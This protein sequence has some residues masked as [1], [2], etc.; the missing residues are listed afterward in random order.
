MKRKI[1]VFDTTLRDGEQVPGAKL[2]LE[3]K[4][5]VAEQL[6]KLKVDMMEV[7]FPSSSKGDFEAVKEISKRFGQ[8][9]VIVGLGR[10]IESDIDAIY[11]SVKYAQNPMIHIVLG[12]SDIHANK[13]F[14]KSKDEI[15]QMGASAVAYAKKYMSSVQYSLEDASRSDIDY[16]WKTIEAV[17][18]AGATIINIPDTVGYA[19]PETFG[20]TIAEIKRR[21]MEFNQDII[22]SVHCHNDTGLATAN[23][24]AAIRNGANK[25]ECTINGIGERAGNASL[26]EIVTS[27][28]LH[29]D[30]YDA[31]TDIN[32][33]E[34]YKTSRI[35]SR[36]MGLDVQV[37]KAITGENAFAHSS[38]I[39]QDGL[40][41]SKNVYEIIDPV[42]IGANE[43][44]LVL[45][46][47]SGQHAF[48][49]IIE[50]MGYEIEK[51]NKS[52]IYNRFIIMADQ[53]KEVYENDIVELIES[54]GNYSITKQPL[55][56]VKNYSVEKKGNGYRGVVEITKGNEQF[57]GEC[58]GEQFVDTIF[59]ATMKAF[60]QKNNDAVQII[61]Y[62]SHQIGDISKSMSK[63]SVQ[64]SCNHNLLD[65]KAIDEDYM[66][67]C[68][69]ACVNGVNKSILRK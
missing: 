49:H 12:S 56:R 2:N 69:M 27:I 63:V 30:Y 19:V 50:K 65:A 60:N 44:E 41:K 67:A 40:L 31:Y 6:I 33:K 35:V 25:V 66:K 52:D 64:M 11:Q 36:T 47:R 24:M 51:M 7:G 34:I 23:S 68:I 28:H 3:E 43:M 38:G 22:L 59:Q 53:K 5:V 26:E 32:K 45:T 18:N 42:E 29:P 4:L 58:K 13:K 9:A 62:R 10:A 46:A 14:S 48:F 61:E 8:D 54:C 15:I 1:Y 57:V 20:Q 37:N 17:V 16:M 21:L 55:Y 39:H